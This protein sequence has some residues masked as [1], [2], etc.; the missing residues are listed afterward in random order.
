MDLI[1]VKRV[2]HT[3]KVDLVIDPQ[4]TDIKKNMLPHLT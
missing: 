1:C 3:Q 2:P 4:H